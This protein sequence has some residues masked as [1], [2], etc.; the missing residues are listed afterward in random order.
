MFLCHGCAG[1][2]FFFFGC[3]VWTSVCGLGDTMGLN[4]AS[5]HSLDCSGILDFVAL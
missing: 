1:L 5:H 2:S 4:I 3:R